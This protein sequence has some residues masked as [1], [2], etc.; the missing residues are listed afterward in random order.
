MEVKKRR[1]MISHLMGKVFMGWSG[2]QEATLVFMEKGRA[3]AEISIARHAR[4][5]GHCQLKG[6]K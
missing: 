4:N 5:T 6:E 1:E 2:L 3:T